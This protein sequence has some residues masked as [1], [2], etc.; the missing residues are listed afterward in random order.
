MARGLINY[1]ERSTPNSDY[2]SG[3]ITDDP[4]DGTG[5]PIDQYTNDDI[6][7]FLDKILR[8][9]GITPNGL[10]ENE[11]SGHQYHQALD[12]IINARISDIVPW[13]NLTLINGW[14]ASGG[15]T[16]QFKVSKD[17]KVHLR[18]SITGVGS[19]NIKFVAD[20]SVPHSNY[21]IILSATRLN[22]GIVEGTRL[23][24]APGGSLNSSPDNTNNNPLYLDGISYW[25]ETM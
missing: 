17:G 16:P 25:P 23:F 11:Y 12:A 15:T 4:G 9:S 21:N 19:S 2:P 24:V 7:Q 6:H 22:A 18:G 10:P 13:T 8:R 20:G 3:R 1:P 5:T 14:A